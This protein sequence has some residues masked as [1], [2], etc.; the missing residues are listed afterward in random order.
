METL[1]AKSLMVFGVF[2]N[3]STRLV[4]KV[5]KVFSCFWMA[6]RSKGIDFPFSIGAS[7]C[8]AKLD[9]Y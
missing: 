6:L 5:L 1:S 4:E 9:R 8:L 2:W 7:V 3:R